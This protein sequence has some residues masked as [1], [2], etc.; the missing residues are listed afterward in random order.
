[1]S[2]NELRERVK[3]PGPKKA[4]RVIPLGNFLRELEVLAYNPEVSDAEF[5]KFVKNSLSIVKEK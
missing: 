4:E 2:D 3:I 1:M 5:R